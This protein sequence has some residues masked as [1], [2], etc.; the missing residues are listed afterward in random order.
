VFFGDL[1][2]HAQFDFFPQRMNEYHY[3][4]EYNDSITKQTL[5]I[6]IH[7]TGTKWHTPKKT[8]NELIQGMKQHP[9]NIT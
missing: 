6:R 2:L 4:D 7:A 8:Y 1:E 9:Y 3:I 5:Y